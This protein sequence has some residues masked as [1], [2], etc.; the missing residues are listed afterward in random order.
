MRL[1]ICLFLCTLFL[2]TAA[3]AGIRTSDDTDANASCLRMTVAA[4]DIASFGEHGRQHYRIV[5]ENRCD[6]VRIVY[7][8]AEH[9]SKTLAATSVCVRGATPQSGIAAPLYA[10][11]RQREFQWTFPP[12]TRIR[13]VDCNN[14]TFPTSD[15]RC[16]ATGKRP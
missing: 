8:C 6:T 4:S 12:G 1:S 14:S 13:Y 9:P 5:F 7:W 11:I 10:V 16:K 3:A 2:H 15:F